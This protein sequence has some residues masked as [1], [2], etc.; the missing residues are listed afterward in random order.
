MPM[1]TPQIFKSVDFTKMQHSRYLKNETF[2]LRIK[3]SL[4]THS[5]V[6]D[7]TFNSMV[8]SSLK[9]IN[10]MNLKDKKRIIK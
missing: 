8:G 2:L 9:E 5:L 3:K 1:I 7:V 4:I 10:N 6:G